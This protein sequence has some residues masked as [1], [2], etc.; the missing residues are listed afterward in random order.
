[1]RRYTRE[2]LK[3]IQNIELDILKNV[4]EVLS[5]LQ[6]DYFLVGG[7]LLGA[8]R[9]KG[10]IPWDDDIDIGM[11]R[12]NYDVFERQGRD[13]LAQKGLFLQTYETDK[14]CGYTYMKIRKNNTEFVE[15]CNRNSKQHQGIYIDVFPFEVVGDTVKKEKRRTFFFKML[16]NLYIYHQTPDITEKPTDC[17]SVIKFIMRRLVHYIVLIIPGSL[18]YKIFHKTCT[19]F[20]EKSGCSYRSLADRIIPELIFTFE[21]IF[22]LQKM[23][24]ETLE[25]NVPQKWDEYLKGMYKNYM[26]LPPE[27]KRVGHRPYKVYF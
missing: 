9:H 11:L 2:E 23:Q 21:E 12:K 20:P 27:E 26:Q 8:V 5:E 10:F 17:F 18:L 19:L 4:V 1:M 3:T 15:Y 16:C 6:L 24:F 22:P 14:F 7:T 25:V 13:L